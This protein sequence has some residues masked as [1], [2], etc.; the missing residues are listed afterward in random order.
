MALVVDIKK[1]L[2][3]FNLE[4]AFEATREKMALLGTSGSGKSMTL[5]CIAGIE[6]PA[7]GKIVLDGQILFDSNKGIDL[8]PQKRQVG[9]LF[10]QYA[11]FPNMTVEENIACGTRQMGWIKRQKAV[12]AMVERMK[13]GGQEKK[14]PAELSGGQQQRVALARILINNPKLLMLDEPFSALDSHLRWQLELELIEVLESYGGTSLLVSHKQDEVYRLSDSV[15]VLNDGYAERKKPVRDLF[16]APSTLSECLILGL[17]N[18]SRARAIDDY[19]VDAIDWGARLSTNNVVPTC[20]SHV[21]VKEDDLVFAN[22]VVSNNITCMINQVID[23]VT[24]TVVMLTTPGGGNGDSRL[25]IRVPKTYGASLNRS[26]R[27]RLHIAPSKVML[28]SQAK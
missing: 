11:L 27:L 8:P 21:V 15:C 6:K 13:L 14:R 17:K 24:S 19:T 16:E 2:P 18:I 1:T 9:Y 10:Q 7:A 3:N 26:E 20:I 23:D 25:Q 12:A 4:V 5:K 28:V 22:G